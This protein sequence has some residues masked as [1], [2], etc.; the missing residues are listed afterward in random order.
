MTISPTPGVASGCGGETLTIF[1]QRGELVRSLCGLLPALAPQTLTFTVSAFVPAQTAMGGSMTLYVNGQAAAVWDGRD[2]AGNIVPS[3]FYHLVLVQEFA[4]GTSARLEKDVFIPPLGQTASVLLKA[5]PNLAHSGDKIFITAVFGAM[6]ADERSFMKI[7]TVDGERVKV[8]PLSHGQ[9]DWDL[10]NN[11]G[12]EV[13]SGI[14]LIVLDGMDPATGA[15]ARKTI[16]V[17]VLR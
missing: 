14:Y 17:V 7:Y 15:P 8:L 4:D 6:P 11:Q 13:S 2:G 5:L 9:T 1:D 10:T 16:K 12:Q 3:S